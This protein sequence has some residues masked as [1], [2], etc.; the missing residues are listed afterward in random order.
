VNKI[1]GYYTTAEAADLLQL[2]RQRVSAIARQEGWE[3]TRVGRSNLYAVAD[4]QRRARLQQ[5]QAAWRLLAIPYNRWGEWWL[6]DP[7]Q[8]I[9]LA[10]PQCGKLAFRPAGQTP[11]SDRAACPSCQWQARW[12]G[13]NWVVE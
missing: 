5:A 13:E 4:V 6:N 9:V 10:C 12:D 2:S 11:Y 8:V 1:P 7:D 3:V